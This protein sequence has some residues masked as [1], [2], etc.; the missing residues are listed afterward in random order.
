MEFS[1]EELVSAL[2]GTIVV[3]NDNKNFK[4]T[5]IDNRKVT[6]DCIFFAIKGERFNANNVAI[7]NCFIHGYFSFFS[8]GKRTLLVITNSFN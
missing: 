6:E 4:G 1:F 3:N 5:C 7:D 2:E 8:S